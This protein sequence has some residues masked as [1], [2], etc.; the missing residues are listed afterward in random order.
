MI[1]RIL[2]VGGASGIGLSIAREMERRSSVERV[3]IVDKKPMIAPT[4]S[5]TEC[6]QF[7][8]ATTD[9]SLFARF[10]DINA[11]MITAGFGELALFKDVSEQYIIDSFNVNTV[12][13]IRLIKFF[14]S[15]LEG[16]DCFYC[17]VMDSIAGWMSS[18]FFAVYGATKAALKI[19]I[20][21]INVE[22]E[23]S[24][25]SNRILNVSPGSIRGTSFNHGKTDISQL[26]GLTKDI[27]AHLENRDDLFVPQYEEIYQEVLDRYHKDFRAEGK[28]S[29]NYKLE[30]GRISK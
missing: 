10:N 18:P 4:D 22:L 5:K 3:Y 27:I 8:L 25:S 26:S 24:G 11:I 13:V 21:S 12:A 9:Y 19:F 16:S 30:S 1:K 20:E 7:D 29:Y 2:I 14:Y 6:F 28:R 23:M 17:G 15:E